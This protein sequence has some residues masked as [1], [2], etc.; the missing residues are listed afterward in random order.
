MPSSGKRCGGVAV[1]GKRF[2]C[3]HTGN[4][5]PL[6]RERI[7]CERLGRIGEKLDAMDTAE[8]LNFLHQKLGTMT[9]TCLRFPEVSYTLTYALDRLCE[10]TSL[11]STLHLFLTQN[12]QFAASLQASSSHSSNLQERSPDSAI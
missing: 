8:L 4:H 12:Q 2:C 3:H 10:I 1:R 9:K 6:S 5:R 11:E 7:L